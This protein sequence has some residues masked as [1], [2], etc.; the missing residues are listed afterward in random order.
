MDHPFRPMMIAGAL[1]LAASVAVGMAGAARAE[2]APRLDLSLPGFTGQAPQAPVTLAGAP[3]KPTPDIADPLAPQARP[4]LVV[5]P[6]S[7]A[8]F[9]KTSVDRHFGKSESGLT[10]SAGFLCGRQQGG[11]DTGG[12]AAYGVDPHG[13]FVGAK[14]SFAF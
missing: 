2:T 1:F 11:G 12:A 8:V 4:K 10:A 14:L 13:R 5:D 7:D 6:L 3:A 9:A